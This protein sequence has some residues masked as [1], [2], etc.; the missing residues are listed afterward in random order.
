MKC[1]ADKFPLGNVSARFVLE[2]SVFLD[3]KK[4]SKFGPL[5]LAAH[6]YLGA[7]SSL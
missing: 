6:K 2:F 7:A 5:T 4:A 3:L 1:G